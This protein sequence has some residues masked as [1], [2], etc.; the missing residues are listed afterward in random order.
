M[1]FRRFLSLSSLAVMLLG[2]STVSAQG[3]E[4]E[5]LELFV[6]PYHVQLNEGETRTMSANAFY[7]D[8]TYVRG[9]SGVEWRSSN[10]ESVPVS[11]NGTIFAAQKGAASIHA[12]LNGHEASQPGTV[13]VGEASVDELKIEISNTNVMVGQTVGVMVN[14]TFSDGET[15][16]VTG[17]V[18]WE[19]VTNDDAFEV[20]GRELTGLN[21][22][23]GYLI[24]HF[25]GSKSDAVRIDVNDAGYL[26]LMIL[27]GST[28][29]AVGS[30]M[31]PTLRAFTSS[32][33]VN[34]DASE[35]SYELSEQGI[36]RSNSDGSLTA[37]GKGRVAVYAIAGNIKSSQPMVITVE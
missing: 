21:E 22:G 12:S 28:T 5:I 25:D 20:D 11:Q 3:A 32:G 37:I 26:D 19:R 18:T 4:N 30:T 13:L 15:E 24:A 31:T 36:V 6:V 35:A 7:A 27:P 10:P 14:A 23:Y 9:V 33:M 29:M 1:Q 8:G 16:D 2:T 34:I 17:A